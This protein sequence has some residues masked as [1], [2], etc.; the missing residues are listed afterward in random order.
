M[1]S[2]ALYNLQESAFRA[3]IAYSN[4]ELEEALSVFYENLSTPSRRNKLVDVNKSKSRKTLNYKNTGRDA[5]NRTIYRKKLP[6]KVAQIDSDYLDE[7]IIGN[8]I[9]CD[10]HLHQNNDRHNRE[11]I[12]AKLPF[13]TPFTYWTPYW[14]VEDV[15]YWYLSISSYEISRL[16]DELIGRFYMT[17]SEIM[18][19]NFHIEDVFLSKLLYMV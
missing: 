8:D 3:D 15:I 2:T 12:N 11:F 17:P 10:N 1:F 14:E 19:T 13:M 4:R 7:D 16:E 9:K 6:I 5:K 18:D